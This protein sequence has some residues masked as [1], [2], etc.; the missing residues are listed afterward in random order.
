MYCETNRI[1]PGFLAVANG[2][3]RAHVGD[4]DRYFLFISRNAIILSPQQ[5]PDKTRRR[6]QRRKRRSFL[7]FSPLN[8]IF[9][10]N[11]NIFIFQNKKKCEATL[12]FV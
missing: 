4:N 5:R 2:S 7:F 12:K 11:E 10:G 1:L 8:P 6:E 3:L 9:S